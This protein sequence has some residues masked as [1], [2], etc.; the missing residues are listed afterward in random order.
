MSSNS[1]SSG[2]KVRHLT[3]MGLG[4]TIGAGLFLGTGVG[5]QA[6][7]PAVLLAYLAA[8]TIAILIMRMLGEMGSV[9]PASGSFSEYADVGIGH[10]AGFT[11]G[12]VYWL[13]TVA[14]LGAEITGASAFVGAWFGVAPWIPA[15]IFVVFFGAVN[16]LRVRAFGEFEF[17]F[18]FIKVAMLIAFLVIGVCLVLGII[19]GTTTAGLELIRDEGFMPNGIGGVAGGLLAVAFAFGGIEVVAI[20]AA[21]SD[22]PKKSLINA[23]RSTVTRISVFYLG[24]VLVIILLLPYSTL[25]A[26]K[27]AADSPFSKVLELAGIPSVVGFM[28]AIIVLALLSAFNAQLYA[29]SRIMFSLAERHQA[30]RLFT[31][32]DSRGV[33]IA[34]I[35]LSIA[36]SAIMV[37]LNFLDDSW[38][39]R[40][41]LNSAGASLLIV[42]GFIAV[43][44]L[45]LRPRMEALMRGRG[46]E[47]PIKMW[48]QPWGTLATLAALIGLALLMLSDAAASIQLYSAA[49]M[50]FILIIAGW[51][52][53]K[54]QGINPT[55][56]T[57]LPGESVS[58]GP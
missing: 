25:G 43:S 12:W 46:E 54:A 52:T 35:T 8:G 29:S 28:E 49:A 1:L 21:E 32:V 23:V 2:L 37:L 7:G 22:Q 26:A 30:P 55:D 47:L 15:L 3:M 31:R 6:A 58:T 41:M 45:R 17:W 16:L 20:A 14:V 36:I 18:A 51:L 11:Q 56:K 38:L 44:Q 9:L 33:P 48:V 57:P 42:W 50:V 39:L 4:S 24:S 40:F 5:I 27:S 19:P 10:W 53:L 13:A 34:A